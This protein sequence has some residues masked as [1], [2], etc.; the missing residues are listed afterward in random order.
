M[1]IVSIER[2][3]KWKDTEVKSA[4]ERRGRWEGSNELMRSQ[5]E[6]FGNENR[7]LRKPFHLPSRSRALIVIV[8]CFD[9]AALRRNR[10]RYKRLYLCKYLSENAIQHILFGSASTISE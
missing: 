7:N 9:V 8:C 1:G 10:S 5:S 2:E 4:F 3:E 6:H